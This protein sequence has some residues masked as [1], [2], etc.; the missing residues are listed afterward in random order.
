MGDVR[1]P[2]KRRFHIN[3]RSDVTAITFWWIVGVSI[4]IATSQ[5]SQS[6]IT[7]WPRCCRALPAGMMLHRWAP[8]AIRILNDLMLLSCLVAL[9][10][11]VL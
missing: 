3:C 6:S 2:W 10:T 8:M 1:S 4:Q 7:V 9:A 11:R 5:F